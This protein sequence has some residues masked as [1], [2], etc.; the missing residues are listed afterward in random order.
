MCAEARDRPT[1]AAAA[2]A[3]HSRLGGAHPE[4]LESSW[5]PYGRACIARKSHGGQGEVP[6]PAAQHWA[7]RKVP[8]PEIGEKGRTLGSEGAG[9]AAAGQAPVRPPSALEALWVRAAEPRV[10]GM[11]RGGRGWSITCFSTH[12]REDY[13]YRARGGG[14]RVADAPDMRA[15]ISA[16]RA[17]RS[18]VPHTDRV[19][20][21]FASLV[22]GDGARHASRSVR[23]GGAAPLGRAAG[24]LLPA[25]GRQREATWEGLVDGS[26]FGYHRS[27]CT[28][29]VSPQRVS[30][31]VNLDPVS[32]GRECTRFAI[33]LSDKQRAPSR[34]S[35]A[36]RVRLSPSP[37]PHRTRLFGCHRSCAPS[38]S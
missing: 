30:R 38:S 23:G 5:R 31:A 16:Y 24:G 14:R 33:C 19:M 10:Q 26:R 37:A 8:A 25:A 1:P 17:N 15:A 3:L 20:T 22:R 28:L 35:R 36:H 9:T 34:C 11:G 7:Q 29:R 12:P 21:L 6:C 13:T 4:C 2:H 32:F 18:L 27:A